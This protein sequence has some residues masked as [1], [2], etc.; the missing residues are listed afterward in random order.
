MRFFL[1]IEII[2]Y[3]CNGKSMM[4]TVR[5]L[6]SWLVWG[7]LAL[8]ASLMVALRLPAVQD[9]AGSKVAEV[10]GEQLGTEVSVGRVDLGFLNRLILDDVTILDQQR[11]PMV[12]VARL[13]AKVDLAPLALG[14]ISVS[15]A[16][17][18]GARLQLSRPTADAPAN[19]Q[20]VLDSLASND[21]TNQTPLDL[22]VNS[23]IVRNSSVTYDQWDEAPTPER[24]NPYHIHV[25]GISGHINLKAL[26]DDS[27]NVNVKRLTCVEQSGLN[28]HRLSFLLTANN[29]GASLQQFQ[30]QLP[31]TEIRMDSVTAT[32]DSERL[33]ESL[34]LKGAIERSRITPSDFRGLHPKLKNYQHTIGL[35]TDFTYQQ[36]RLDI[37]RLQA[38]SDKGDISLEANGY[39]EH[40]EQGRDTWQLQVEHL[41]VASETLDFL[42]KNIVELPDMVL[43]LGDVR[44]AGSFLGDAQGTI[45]TQAGIQTDL[46]RAE[47]ELQLSEDKQFAGNISTDGVDIGRLTGNDKLGN[48]AL[49]VEVNGII[50]KQIAAKG[51]IGKIEYDGTSYSNIDLDATYATNQLTGWLQIAD[52]KVSARAEL[53]LKATTLNDAVG[54]VSL[55]NLSLPEKDYS[56][57][58]LRVE[59]GFDEGRHFVTLNSDFAHANLSGEF[60]YATLAQSVANAIGARLP[61]LPDLPPYR[62][63]NNNFSL[64]MAM[65][66]TDWLQKLLDVSLDIHQPVQ[67]E[68][69]VNDRDKH[70]TID[71]DA[72]DFTFNDSRYQNGVVHITTPSDSLFVNAAIST[73]GDEGKRYDIRAD[74]NAA[75]NN[76]SLALKWNNHNA[77]KPLSGTLNL[78]SHLYKNIDNKPEA[79]VSILPSNIVIDNSTWQVEP[80]DILYST[81]RMLIDHF[82]VHNGEQYIM[83]DGTASKQKTDSVHV[84]LKGV[85]VG[86]ILDLVAFD[87]V[88]FAGKA[89]GNACL[90]SVL[91]APDAYADLIV[92]D[93]KFQEGRMGTLTAHVDWN[94]QQEQIDISATANDGLEATTYIN[95]YVSPEREYI[96]LGISAHGTYLDFMHSFTE[97]F[98]SEITGHGNGNLRLAGPLDAINLTGGLRIDGHASITPLNT[99]YTLRD[100]SLTL[101]Y[102]E[103]LLDSLR[104]YDKYENVGY[105]SG[106]VHHEDLTNLSLDLHVATDRL[107]GYDFS[108]FGDQSFYGTVFASGDVDISL[109]G[110]DVHIDCNVTPLTGSTFVYNADQNDGI[111]DQEFITWK[112]V[113]QKAPNATA[114]TASTSSTNIYMSF[115]VNATPEG[116]LR[117]LM[118]AK[119]G[120]YITLNG[121]GTL[122]ATY[123]NKGTFEMQGT[124][125]VD[126]GT[127]DVTI[128]NIINKKF[129]F[130]PGGTIIFGGDP[131]AAALNLQALYTV[132]GVSLSDL[133][134]GN[135]F[136]SNT[137]RVNCL[138]NIGGQ[139]SAPQVTFDL[140]MPTVNADEKQMVR[141]LLSSQQEMNQ[142]VLYLLGIGR[143]YTLGQNNADQQPG[144]PDQTTLAMQ[145]FLS[146]TLST[147]INNVL[148]QVIGNDSWNFGANIATGTEGWNNAEYEGT[149]AGRMLDN[150]LLINGQFGYR[151]NATQATPSFIGDFDIRYLLL[152]NG[153]LA[154]KV[155]NQTNDRY[156]TRSSL[157]TQGVGIIMK[158]DFNG[159]RDFFGIKDKEKGM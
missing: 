113:E 78:S 53:D 8:V 158:K 24:F 17:L 6:V 70:I 25:A 79:Q 75:D 51:N 18:L 45:Y 27:L 99:T 31:S 152:P 5:K 105:L 63:S 65:G 100:D 141:S 134:L 33:L 48:V 123:Y 16:Q 38:L 35:A 36:G 133:Q 10:L 12:K 91:D 50:D 4:K 40:P 153:N 37:G 58:Y 154:L 102:N 151:D 62:Q 73:L 115:L 9:W 42:S 80:S 66:K 156:F 116:T 120:D 130:Q 98:I 149:V 88:T 22:R 135:S 94:K 46:G 41:A 129:Q 64:K 147:Q 103:I 85:E 61:T 72:P 144:Q 77:D 145:S 13:T 55:H 26:R 121:S 14:R 110:D 7:L 159:L 44:L 84:S 107:L 23:F 86:Y 117:L 32:Y 114:Q 104:I 148:N 101:V 87:A 127:Y 69:V 132:N 155:Y 124:Y 136:S 119:T 90:T 3:L 71:L 139:P 126:H 137:I 106:A 125:T 76:L 28:I 122:Q 93:F 47:A 109:R 11:H 2:S 128:Q 39:Y 67:L 112:K 95:G 54:V 143:F 146:G 49:G 68:A 60:D 1:S 157:N 82:S 138:M 111:S 30:L 142:Q 43:Q 20:F 92:N 150:R 108:D 118:D 15:S 56:L 131:Y 57:E 97:S 34:R 83:V 52:P 74:G 29:R 59:S 89:S 140:D 96:D 21:T 81:D 19:Y